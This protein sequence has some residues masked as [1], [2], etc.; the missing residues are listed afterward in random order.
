MKLEAYINNGKKVI[1]RKIDE[2]F[3]L[4]KCYNPN[5]PYSEHSQKTFNMLIE[6]AR[7]PTHSSKNGKVMKIGDCNKSEIKFYTNPNEL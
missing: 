2:D 1:S 4:T 6:L 5:K 3:L 7:I